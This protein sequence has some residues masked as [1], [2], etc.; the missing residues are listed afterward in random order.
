[1]GK[2]A[3]LHGRARSQ[4]S[5]SIIDRD[6]SIKT[7]INDVPIRSIAPYAYSW[8]CGCTVSQSISYHVPCGILRDLCIKYAF[9]AG[10]PLCGVCPCVGLYGDGGLCWMCLMR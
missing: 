10:D 3:A 9:M 2:L 1:M 8:R 4:A 6:Q 7:K 5:P